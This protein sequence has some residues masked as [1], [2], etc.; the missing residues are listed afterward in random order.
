MQVS[1][2][3]QM[4]KYKPAR[5]KSDSLTEGKEGHF[6]HPKWGCHKSGRSRWEIPLWRL[7]TVISRKANSN[8]ILSKPER[9]ADDFHNHCSI[10]TSVEVSPT[11][12]NAAQ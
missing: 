5:R 10:F 8:A 4:E 3:L 1:V 2:Y 6:L 12:T 9:C 11:T 7:E